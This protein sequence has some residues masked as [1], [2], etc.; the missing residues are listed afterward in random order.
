MDTRRAIRISPRV[1][2]AARS[3]SGRTRGPPSLGIAAAREIVRVAPDKAGWRDS[4]RTPQCE[5]LRQP[6]LLPAGSRSSA[7]LC[8]PCPPYTLSLARRVLLHRP[9]VAYGNQAGFHSQG[10][11]TEAVSHDTIE[12]TLAVNAPADAEVKHKDR[13]PCPQAAAFRFQQEVVAEFRHGVVR[14][15]IDPHPLD[16]LLSSVPPHRSRTSPSIDLE[17]VR[18]MSSRSSF[19][20]GVGPR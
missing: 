10:S 9:E 8:P 7:A 13:Q 20:G 19:G 17:R 14:E 12:R 4:Q 1:L 11:E 2:F 18:T 16:R 15:R 3:R 5:E 6:S